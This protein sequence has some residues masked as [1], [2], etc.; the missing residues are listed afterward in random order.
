MYMLYN[1]SPQNLGTYESSCCGTEEI[2]L[3][4]NHEALGSISGLTQWI[5][6]PALPWAVV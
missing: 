2:N 6:N 4:R 5:K 1:K 3:T